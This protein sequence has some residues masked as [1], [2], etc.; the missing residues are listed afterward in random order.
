MKVDEVVP[1]GYNKMEPPKEGGEA[2][3]VKIHFT[4]LSMD[5]I[6]ENSMVG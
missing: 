6:D 1:A 4:V 5:T 2:T 3:E